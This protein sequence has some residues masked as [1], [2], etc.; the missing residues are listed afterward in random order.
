MHGNGGCNESRGDGRVTVPRRRATKRQP[1]VRERWRKPPLECFWPVYIGATTRTTSHATCRRCAVSLLRG[2]PPAC[3][4]ADDCHANH[5]AEPIFNKFLINYRWSS[6]T[7]GRA[8]DTGTD[9]GRHTSGGA[10]PGHMPGHART[11]PGRV[12]T[13]GMRSVAASFV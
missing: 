10:R 8:P 11:L 6:P 1:L 3:M 13:Y 2:N 12:R 7:S 9:T 5:M 4:R